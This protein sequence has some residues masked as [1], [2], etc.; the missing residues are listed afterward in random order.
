MTRTG[1]SVGVAA[2]AAGQDDA[3]L[4]APSPEG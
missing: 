1:L 2:P 4:T 3:I